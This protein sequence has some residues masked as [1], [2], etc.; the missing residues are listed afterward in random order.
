MAGPHCLVRW[1]VEQGQ[2]TA[3][4]VPAVLLTAYLLGLLHS[5]QHP[6]R[7]PALLL[8]LP[9]VWRT[10]CCWAHCHQQ[11]Q[12]RLG[13]F[14][15]GRREQ[16]SRRCRACTAPVS[17]SCM[18]EGSGA[19]ALLAL[20]AAAWWLHLVWVV[21]QALV[22]QQVLGDR[23]VGSHP[24]AA[25]QAPSPWQQLLLQAP[26]SCLETSPSS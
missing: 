15:Q 24:P 21:V 11:Q 7:W 23:S 25:W 12:G 19:H 22:A 6:V 13:G 17:T 2:Q 26:A 3:A 1:P 9:L 18:G 10:V 16:S 4:R 8:L 20:A 14:L 5:R